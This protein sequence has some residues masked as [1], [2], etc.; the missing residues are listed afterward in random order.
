VTSLF[1]LAEYRLEIYY[2]FGVLC[3]GSWFAFNLWVLRDYFF[4]WWFAPIYTES[5][6]SKQKLESMTQEILMKNR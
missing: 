2:A 5:G 6:L 4:P 1:H 3:L